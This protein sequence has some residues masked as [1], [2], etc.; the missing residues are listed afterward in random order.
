MSIVFQFHI[1]RPI[2]AICI[3]AGVLF[4]LTVLSLANLF[5]GNHIDEFFDKD[6][7]NSDVQLLFQNAEQLG[8]TKE[9]ELNFFRFQGTLES[10]D[11][12]TTLVFSTTDSVEIFSKKVHNLAITTDFS[13][14]FVNGK[15]FTENT[16]VTFINESSARTL[17]IADSNS[18]YSL[19]PVSRTIAPIVT[20]W[21]LLISKPKNKK[22]K[23]RIH[24]AQLPTAALFW[25]DK[26]HGKTW[27]GPIVVMVLSR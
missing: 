16:F 18:E 11:D 6:A 8:Y 12:I 21:N 7:Y 22:M 24:F 5:S 20:K 25:K 14:D 1:P 4:F 13:L 23:L 26:L 2:I 15:Q 19:M 3:G 9:S 10:R 17:V 27:L